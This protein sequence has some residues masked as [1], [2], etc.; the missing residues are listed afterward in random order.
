MHEIET[1]CDILVPIKDDF[2]NRYHYERLHFVDFVADNLP[3]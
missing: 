3:L 1:Q 2:G